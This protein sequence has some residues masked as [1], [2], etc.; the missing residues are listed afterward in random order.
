M[1]VVLCYFSSIY[2]VI[3]SLLG[4][5]VVIG[6]IYDICLRLKKKPE[7]EEREHVTEMTYK[8]T[9]GDLNLG[10]IKV[11]LSIIN[12]GTVNGN[13]DIKKTTN[14]DLKIQNTKPQSVTPKPS[15]Q[16]SMYYKNYHIISRSFW[17]KPFAWE[18]DHGYFT[19]DKPTG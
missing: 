11:D 4:V 6:T 2:S 19:Y 12:G 9:N 10:E 3:L 1:H 7:A 13:L 5:V 8:H 15:E 17:I 18:I 14:E 16:R